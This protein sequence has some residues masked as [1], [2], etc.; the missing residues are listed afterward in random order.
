M[1]RKHVTN[2]VVCYAYYIARKKNK[3]P[4]FVYKFLSRVTKE[5]EKVCFRA[6]ERACKKGLI[7]FGVSLQCGWLSDKGKDLLQAFLRTRNV[8]TK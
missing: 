5:Q 2:D 1:S 6:M 4:N 7:N 3:D 8:K